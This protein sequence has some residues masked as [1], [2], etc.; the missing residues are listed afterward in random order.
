MFI[1]NVD[2]T[3]RIL[4]R[5]KESNS[6]RLDG[7]IT[8]TV[9]EDSTQPVQVVGI[10]LVLCRIP[11]FGARNFKVI[12]KGFIRRPT[13]QV[14]GLNASLVDV[15]LR[16]LPQSHNALRF[17]VHNPI[18]AISYIS[19]QHHFKYIIVYWLCNLGII[20]EPEEVVKPVQDWLFVNPDDVEA[21]HVTV[22]YPAVTR[23]LLRNPP[24]QKA[25]M[26]ERYLLEK[27]RILACLT[28]PI[29]VFVKVCFVE[30]DDRIVIFVVEV[31]MQ[32]V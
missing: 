4:S 13:L 20:I 25:G 26:L 24:R 12:V 7:C 22:S 6:R 31:L 15:I 10:F 11:K 1:A 28:N 16:G 30:Y 5:N 29:L 8:P 3:M 27:Q 14:L 23:D 9:E 32:C 2:K 17:I 19:L 18:E 21:A